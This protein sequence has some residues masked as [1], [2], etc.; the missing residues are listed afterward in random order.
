[1]GKIWTATLN[2]VNS[3]NN[4]VLTDLVYYVDFYDNIFPNVLPNY[5][6]ICDK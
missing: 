5:V 2:G 3:R 6:A 4:G 1:M